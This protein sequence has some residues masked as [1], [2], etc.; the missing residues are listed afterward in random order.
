MGPETCW[1]D[2]S[3]ESTVYSHALAARC[4]LRGWYSASADPR[5]FHS[6]ICKSYLRTARLV[7]QPGL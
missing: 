7:L 6:A 4:N 5:E 2:C 3:T 1:N